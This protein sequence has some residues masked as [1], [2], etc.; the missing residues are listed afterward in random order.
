MALHGHV[1]A[2]VSRLRLLDPGKRPVPRQ[3]LERDV[4]ARDPRREDASERAVLGREFRYEVLRA[5]ARKH[6]QTLR[7]DLREITDAGLAYHRR[8]ARSE[9][10]V[11]KHALV[12]DVAYET[13]LRSN[14]QSLHNR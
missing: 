13:M 12:R 4:H 6:E 10:Y 3:L 9:S 14:R 7:E 8:S 11:F 1:A 2:F 5:V